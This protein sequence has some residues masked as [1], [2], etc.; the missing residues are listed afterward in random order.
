MKI[1]NFI[2]QLFKPRYIDYAQIERLRKN[3]IR[4]VF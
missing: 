1:W 2:K 3:G 4:A